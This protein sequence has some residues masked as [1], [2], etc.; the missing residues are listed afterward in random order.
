MAKRPAHD[1]DSSEKLEDVGH[2]HKKRQ[3]KSPPESQT[4]LQP[5]GIPLLGIV[6]VAPW[7][8]SEIPRNLP[9]IPPILDAELERNVYDHAGSNQARRSNYQRLEWLGDA[10][11]E[12]IASSLI[13]QTFDQSPSG[14]CSQIRELLVR[15]TTLAG[16]FREYG[17]T[18]KA[19][20]PTELMNSQHLGRGRSADK[21]LMKTQ[22]DMFEAY[23]AAAILSDPQNGLAKTAAWLKALWSRTIKDTIIDNE[24]TTS[25]SLFLNN[26]EKLGNEGETELNPKDKLRFLIGCKGV[27]IHYEDM[28]G[29]GKDKDLGLPLFAVGVY[30]DAWGEKN[31]LLGIGTA[32]QKKEA[33]QKAAAQALQNKKLIKVYEAKKRAF[34]DAARAAEEASAGQSAA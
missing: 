26:K 32:L 18:S 5:A 22:S 31:K 17:L 8:A 33:G 21:D 20:L 14:R 11:L 12:L 23:V 9:P 4:Q 25:T 13:Y 29:G 7:R 15:N 19:Q 6:T 1:F 3:A 2:I 24:K 16:Y 27:N 10:Y 28:P 30:L 34:Q